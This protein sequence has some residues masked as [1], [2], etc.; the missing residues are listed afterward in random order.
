MVLS[1]YGGERVP[2]PYPD[3]MEWLVLRQKSGGRLGGDQQEI[4]GVQGE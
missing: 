1:R 2:V 4:D 3:T